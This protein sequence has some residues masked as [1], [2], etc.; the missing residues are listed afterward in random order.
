MNFYQSALQL[1]DEIVAY[2][3]YL[4]QNAEA[5]LDMPLSKEF[6]RRNLYN[7]GITAVDCGCGVTATIGCGKP[8]IL[9]RADMDALP[10]EEQSGVDFASCTNAAHTCGHDMHAAMLLGAAKL[11]K[12]QETTLKGTVKLMF[13]PG[14]EILAG[15]D[16]M[17]QKGILSDPVPDVALAFH[18]GAGKLP[19]GTFM[20]NAGGVMMNSADNFNI[21]VFGK[22]GHGAYP[23]LA[24]DPINA[25]VHIYTAL[26]GMLARETDPQKSCNL[27]IG[28]FCSGES[29]NIIPD[30]ANMAGSVRTNDNLQRSML[31]RR[32]EEI[33]TNVANACGCR[34]DIKWSGGAPCLVCDKT[35]TE[36]MVK[37]ISDIPLSQ[38]APVAG[39]S[40]SASE[41]FANIAQKI[42]SAMIYLGAG[43][44][45]S[46][47]DYTAHNP[48]VQFN[49][50]VLPFG[51][52]AYARCA[53]CWLLDNQT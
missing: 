26:Q 49:E 51:A 40:A 25:A 11:L 5:G 16:N 14:E 48:K 18:V 29:G 52:A 44:A 2:R 3:R 12:Q 46:R 10:M 38:L 23:H 33:V 27:T 6:I 37:Y 50:E 28:S 8:V 39:M 4:H 42:P 15:C 30:T 32:I 35:F 22:G 13:Q 24:K 7:M 36:D 34:A 45:D 47:G 53:V 1:K 9:L 43:F 41:D 21:T 31:V 20:Y 19:V 17:L